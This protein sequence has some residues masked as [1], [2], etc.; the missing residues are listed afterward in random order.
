MRTQALLA[1]NASEKEGVKRNEKDSG[2]EDEREESRGVKRKYNSQYNPDF[3]R[4]P[5]SR[6]RKDFH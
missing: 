1:Q 6:R 2:S 5:K 3:V 4:Q